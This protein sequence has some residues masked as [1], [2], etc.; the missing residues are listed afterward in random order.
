MQ[1]VSTAALRP[2]AAITATENGAA[3]NIQ[4][5][6][7]MAKLVLDSS[8]V[9][10]GTSTSKIQDSADGSTDWTDV[11]GWAFTAVATSA[12]RQE[13]LVNIDKARKFVR[14]VTTMAGGAN[15]Q[16]YNVSLVGTKQAI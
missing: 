13:L 3:V 16:S 4:D 15:V 2:T 14:V 10:A 7:G 6:Q 11:S 1:K 12:S 5:F 8:A 9:N